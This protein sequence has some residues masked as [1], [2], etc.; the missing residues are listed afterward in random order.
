MN[1][2]ELSANRMLQQCKILFEL[3]TESLHVVHIYT[4]SDS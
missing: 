2:N 3:K 1:L 4:L